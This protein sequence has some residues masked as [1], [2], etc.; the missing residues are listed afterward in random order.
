MNEKCKPLVGISCCSNKVGIHQQQFVGD[1]YIQAIMEGA[2]VT[3]VLLPSFGEEM[4]NILPHLDGLYLTGSYSNM[5]PKHFGGQDLG[6]DM[7][8]DPNRDTTNLALIKQALQLKMPVFGICRGF[9]EMNVALG[10]S[11]C[12]QVFNRPGAI[13]H[14]EN[15]QQSL[16]QQYAV[17]HSV[18]LPAGGLLNQW[19]KG[20]SEQMVNSLHGQGVDRLGAGL[21]AEAIAPDG[22]VEAFSLRDNDSFYL[23]VQ[24][25]PEW[26]LADH[27]FYH[28]LFQQFGQACGLYQQNKV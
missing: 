26:K 19:M 1:K 20:E 6:V 27:P 13:E 18:T 5:E 14:R 15:K 17:A 10:G 4:L 28:T 22:L 23:G 3:P 24:W 2:G 21:R 11:L 8:R 16:E 9:Q 25:H 12:Q 7:P